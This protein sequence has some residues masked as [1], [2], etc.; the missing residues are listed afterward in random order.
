MWREIDYLLL[1]T[2]PPRNG[3]KI[4]VNALID[5]IDLI[6]DLDAPPEMLQKNRDGLAKFEASHPD[7]VAEVRQQRKKRKFHWSGQSRSAIVGGADRPGN[8]RSLHLLDR[9]C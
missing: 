4:Q 5:V 7:V 8:W 6:T 1:S 3:V 2:D 9:G